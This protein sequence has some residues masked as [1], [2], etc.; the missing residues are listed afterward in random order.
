MLSVQIFPMAE[1]VVTSTGKVFTILQT[2]RELDGA[3]LSEVAR[4]LNMPKSTVHNYFET[5]QQEEYLVNEGGSYHVG[6]RLL[7]YGGYARQ[8]RDVFT[9]AK[10]ELDTLAEETGELV[11]LLVEEHGRG[12]YVYRAHGGDAVQVAPHAGT[13]VHL[14][15]TALGKAVLAHLPSEYRNGVLEEHGLPGRTRKTMTSRNALFEELEQIRERGFAYDDGE[16]RDG[17]RCVAV[18]VVDTDNQ[19]LGAI[20]I[21]GPKNRFQGAWFREELPEK[22][23]ETANVVKLNVPPG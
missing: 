1:D 9:A 19:V 7:K 18:P 17:L 13:R 12:C 3:T 4:K 22:L 20:G 21:S 14:H 5:L 11:N 23:L 6:I 10:P 15:S 8:Q 2:I 16:W